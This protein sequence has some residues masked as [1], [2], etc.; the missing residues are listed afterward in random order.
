MQAEA[1]KK[2]NAW[3]HLLTHGETASKAKC[4]SHSQVADAVGFIDIFADANDNLNS[5][6]ISDQTH[7]SFSSEF[8]PTTVCNII[9]M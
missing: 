1:V 9:V 8:F 6:V 5:I 4:F 2:L 7:N 3:G